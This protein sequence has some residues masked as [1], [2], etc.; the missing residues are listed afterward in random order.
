M[1]QQDVESARR[2]LLSLPGDGVCLISHASY[3]FK[4]NGVLWA[5]DPA[6]QVYTLPDIPGLSFVLVTHSHPDHYHLP[7]L[8]RLAAQGAQVVAPAFLPGIETLPRAILVSAGDEVTLQNISV[9]VLPARHLDEGTD[10]GV[11][12]VGYWV[13]TPA[14]TVALP[15]D[16]R[17]Y[18]CPFPLRRPNLLMAHV[19]LGRG[20]A[21]NL[22]CEPWRSKAARFFHDIEAERV[23]FTHLHDFTRAPEDMWTEAHAR[24]LMPDVPHGQIPALF[25]PIPL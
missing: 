3:L 2:R 24:L 21:L 20:N 10:I 9:S 5:V 17:D 6:H 11:E 19:W 22:P 4:T 25:D 18:T 1:Y 14:R 13:K 7:T 16:I 23:L 15:G 12:E 8:T